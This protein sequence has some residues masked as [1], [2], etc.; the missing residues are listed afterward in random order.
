MTTQRGNKN[1]MATG[2]LAFFA[3]SVFFGVLTG[4]AVELELGAFTI[5]MRLVASVA[6]LVTA[7]VLAG[8]AMKAGR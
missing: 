2:A 5:G 1:V 6:F 3:L 7:S 8:K 4:V